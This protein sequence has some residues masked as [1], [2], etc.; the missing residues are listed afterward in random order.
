MQTNTT[1]LPSQSRAELHPSVY[2]CCGP[3]SVLCLVQ[4]VWSVS[5]S[6][7][8]VALKSPQLKFDVSGPSHQNSKRMAKLILSGKHVVISHC[9]YVSLKYPRLTR[10]SVDW[11]PCYR[12]AFQLSMLCVLS[13]TSLNWLLPETP[14]LCRVWNCSSTLFVFLLSVFE[15]LQAGRKSPGGEGRHSSFWEPT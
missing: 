9:L 14:F 15:G 6:A 7:T 4:S 8:A 10:L 1:Y 13:T 12:S 11:L 3:E 2:C 5:R